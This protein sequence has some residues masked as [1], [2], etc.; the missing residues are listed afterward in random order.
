MK[1][2]VKNLAEKRQ[3]FSSF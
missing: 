3:D 2:N 1:G